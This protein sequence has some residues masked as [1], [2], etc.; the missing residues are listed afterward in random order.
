MR[1]VRHLAV[2]FLVWIVA[3]PLAATEVIVSSNGWHTGIAVARTDIPPD[4]LPETADFP[5]AKWF[6]FGW[7]DAEYYPAPKPGMIDAL[8]AAFPGPAVVHMSGLPGHPATVFAGSDRVSL[9]LS[10]PAFARLLAYLDASFER[11]GAARVRPSAQGLYAFS[12][13]YPATG[14]F[15][16]FNTCNTW[17]A[18]A[19]AASG[20]P[21]QVEGTQRAEDV[22]RQLH[23]LSSR[24]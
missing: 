9:D 10:D 8:S 11:R 6:E 5:A 12:L 17:T 4:V 24:R 18:R 15:H 23:A 22:M 2:L 13:F 3:H 21:V 19:L 1:I 7:G 16:L 14:R 20:V